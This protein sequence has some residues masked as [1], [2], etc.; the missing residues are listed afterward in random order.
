MVTA[1]LIYGS[2]S[3]PQRILASTPSSIGHLRSPSS[4]SGSPTPGAHRVSVIHDRV[5]R[6]ISEA[7]SDTRRLRGDDVMDI[8]SEEPELR[9]LMLAGLDVDAAAHKALLA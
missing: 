1:S 6:K 3:R 7:R 2:W 9:T 8:R 5:L 4:A